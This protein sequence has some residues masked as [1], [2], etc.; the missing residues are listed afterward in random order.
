MSPENNSQDNYGAASFK[1]HEKPLNQITESADNDTVIPVGF[2]KRSIAFALDLLFVVIISIGI[3]YII[4]NFITLPENIRNLIGNI[5]FLNHP[6]AVTA[7]F[8]ININGIIFPLVF[9]IYSIFF[10]GV[11]NTTLGKK[12]FSIFI[13]SNDENDRFTFLNILLRNLVKNIFFI[14]ALIFEIYVFTQGNPDFNHIFIVAI[15][16]GIIGL[17]NLIDYIKI[18]LSPNKTAFHDD[19]S[20]TQVVQPYK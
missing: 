1:L 7:S 8:A 17:F 18:G 13:V 14:A 12:A 11:F 3:L 20:S 9:I 16:V 19:M 10:E 2:W 15:V 4:D 6:D 5:N